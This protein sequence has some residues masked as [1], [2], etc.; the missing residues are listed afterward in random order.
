MNSS[1]AVCLFWI[2]STVPTH[3]HCSLIPRPIFRM[4]LGWSGMRLTST[5]RYSSGVG[6]NF[7]LGGGG[8][9]GELGGVDQNKII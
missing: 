6:T 1:V 2:T 9:Q 8:G 7:V 4:G 3:L 5:G